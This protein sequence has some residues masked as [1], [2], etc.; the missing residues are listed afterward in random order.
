MIQSQFISLST[1]DLLTFQSY[2]YDDVM[3]A[4]TSVNPEPDEPLPELNSSGVCL[5][6]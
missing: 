1:I 6:L 4:T 3:S 2:K 5:I